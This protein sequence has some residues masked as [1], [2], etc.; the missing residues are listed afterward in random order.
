MR[1]FIANFI[2]QF[3]AERIFKIGEHLARFKVTGSVGQQLAAAAVRRKVWLPFR[4]VGQ[5]VKARNSDIHCDSEKNKTRY[6]CP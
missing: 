6:F 4:N 2:L 3:A 5:S 1:Y